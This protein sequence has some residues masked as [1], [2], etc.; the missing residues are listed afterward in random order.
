M[1]N[2]K[3]LEKIQKLL[4]STQGR[5]ILNYLTQ[6]KESGEIRTLDEFKS[7]LK[8]LTDTLLGDRIIPTLV[9]NKAIAGKD[10][11]SETYNK[12]LQQLAN[13]LETCFVEANNLDEIISAHHNLIKDVSFKTIKL[14]IAK[15]ESQ[16]QLYEF[17]DKTQIG[18]DDSQF[19]TFRETDNLATSRLDKN[20]S[21]VFSDLLK[22]EIINEEEAADIDPVGERLCLGYN[23]QKFVK[24]AGVRLLANENSTRSEV[25][26]SFTNANINNIIDGQNNTFWALPVL[27]S[28]I[29]TSGVSA[30]VQIDLA[31]MQEINF[32]EI[33]PV[34]KF[35]MTITGIDYLDSAYIRTS[36]ISSDIKLTKQTRINFDKVFAKSLIIT[37]RQEAFSEI[38]FQQIEKTPLF[39]AVITNKYN[40]KID[41]SLSSIKNDL[42][43]IV[44]SDFLK[45]IFT[46]TDEIEPLSRYY[47]YVFALDNVRLGYATYLDRSVYV[48]QSK[49][50][51]KP[52][53]IGLTTDELRPYIDLSTNDQGIIEFDYPTESSTENKI[54]YKGSLEYNLHIFSYN[55]SDYLFSIDSIPVLPYRTSRI[56]HERLFFAEKTDVSYINNNAGVLRFFTNADVSTIYMYKN[57]ILLE[58]G[59]DWELYNT[60]TISNPNTGSPMKRGIRLLF[61][62]SPLDIFTVSYNPVQSNTMSR[63]S[64]NTG[65]L[66]NVDLTG[67]N[68]IRIVP[69]NLIIMDDFR[70]GHQLDHIDVYLQIVLRNNSSDDFVSPYLEEYMLVYNSKDEEKFTK[71]Y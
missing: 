21:I 20:M 46:I 50:I 4:P 61:D 55:E 71:D 39:R 11:D 67:D 23:V 62:P 66:S 69:E 10:I 1:S 43:S 2:Y 40:T 32:L 56:Y 65:L 52:T 64:S 9:L 63:I 42:K 22:K 51:D 16:I 33:D 30:E 53:L 13:D 59:T 36:L 41:N 8:E 27:L 38:Q 18:V 3:Y 68:T 47:E 24:L 49:R 70:K 34:G 12:M 44:T 35:P 54:F 29:N 25:D 48:G 17:I 14:A 60:L 45:N 19:N 6:Q 15:L 58:C 5:H 7:H 37:F 31:T 28:N 26:A 57:G